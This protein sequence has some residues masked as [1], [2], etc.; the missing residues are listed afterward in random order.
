MSLWRPAG[1]CAFHAAGA[2]WPGSPLLPTVRTHNKDILSSSATEKG[3]TTPKYFSIEKDLNLL[4]KS[5]L[6]Q[7]SL[8]ENQELSKAF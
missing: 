6:L 4:G 1:S 5:D 2:A 8:E 7:A 3:K